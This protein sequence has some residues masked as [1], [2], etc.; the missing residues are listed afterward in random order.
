MSSFVSRHEQFIRRVDGLN[1]CFKR[2]ELADFSD[3]EFLDHF[4]VAMQDRYLT[5]EKDMYCSM[6]GVKIL[7]KA[8]KR[9]G[10]E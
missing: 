3:Q 1:T 5:Q 2:T 10:E 4:T 8:L 7:S 6:Q 9:I